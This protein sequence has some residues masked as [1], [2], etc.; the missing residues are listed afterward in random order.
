[1]TEDLL[2]TVTVDVPAGDVAGA[3]A[4]VHSGQF[5]DYIT[6][7]RHGTRYFAGDSRAEVRMGR[8]WL[9]RTTAGVTETLDITGNPVRALGDCLNSVLDPGGRA[10]GYLSFEL[11]R[12]LH[13]AAPSPADSAMLAH[14]IVPRIEV[15]WSPDRPGVATIRGDDPDRVRAVGDV[16][17]SAREL[18]AV[19]VTP[20]TLTSPDGSEAYRSLVSRAVGAIRAGQLRKAIL[21]RRV[22]VPFPVDLPRTYAVGLAR[23]T[24]ARSFLLDLGGRRCAGFSPET[25][26]E[27]SSDGGVSTQPLAGT[28]ALSDDPGRNRALRTDLEWNVKECY[29]HVISARLADAELRTICDPDTVAIRGLLSVLERGTVQHLASRVVGRLRPGLDIW[30]AVAA[31][32][33]AVTASGIPKR[34]ALRVISDLEDSD[35]GMYSGA[36]CVVG[37]GEID[38]ALVLRSVFQNPDGGTWL[39]AGAGI[40]ENSDPVAEYDETTNKLASVARCLVAAPALATV[41]DTRPATGPATSPATGPAT[42]SATRPATSPATVPAAR[43]ATARA[44]AADIRRAAPLTDRPGKAM[45]MSDE[46]AVAQAFERGSAPDIRAALTTALADLGIAAD[47]VRDEATLRGDLELDSTETVQ[48][49]LEL[50]RHLGV[51]VSLS[52]KGDPPV[53]ELVDLVVEQVREANQPGAGR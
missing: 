11:A 8:H 22:E 48:I 42:P 28:R 35:R 23:N 15:I 41:L 51:K 38:S 29:E 37:A 26:L 34:D 24:P 49:A 16:L 50:T 1:M 3:L 40:V 2:P 4:L 25:V 30:D 19:R 52:G 43:L 31:L 45:T 32:F 7:E 14:F 10:Y 33:P 21:S 12:L 17:A 47:E 53:T 13:D 46:R 5:T 20:V 39:Q 18:P 36:V 27:I 6:Y 9:A 44:A